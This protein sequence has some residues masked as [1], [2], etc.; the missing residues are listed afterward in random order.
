[1][2][3][4]QLISALSLKS[5]LSKLLAVT[6]FILP[7]SLPLSASA[8][9]PELVPGKQCIFNDGVFSLK[10]D[11]YNPGQ[12]IFVGESK[13]DEKDYTKYKISG[14]PAQTDNNVTVGVRSC[15]DMAN[16]VAVA[17]IVGHSIANNSI[18]IATGT[19]VGIGT[20]LLGAVA[21]VFTA[22]GACPAAAAGVGVAVSGAVAGVG[23]ALPEVKEIAYIGSPG[24][25]NY[26]DL[27]GTIWQVGV[28]NNIPLTK[29][30]GFRRVV[31]FVTDGEPGPKSITFK[32]QAGYVAE[33]VVMY[34][35]K[36]D[37]GAI[38]GR[39][40]GVF[41]DMPVTVSSGKVSLGFTRHVDI[42]VAISDK[43][44]QIFIKGVGT[45]KSDVYSDAVTPNFAGNYCFK[46][47]GSIFDAK[48]SLC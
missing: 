12:V 35:Q 47:Y 45:I 48:G 20:S 27:S 25:K 5:K 28:A 42:P 36:Q 17:R 44:V 11:W 7:L 37:P 24:T 19:S 13:A 38:I 15:T 9:T 16:R 21:C 6:T 22:G 18:V 32:N 23:Q 3:K 4:N 46:A 39:P 26:V 30:R 40:T 43:Q 41:V 29:A 1:M 10:V 31:E 14:E 8:Q 2:M 34:F 33:M